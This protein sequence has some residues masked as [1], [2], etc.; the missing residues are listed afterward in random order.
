MK[1]II[2]IDTDYITCPL[3]DCR[4]VYSVYDSKRK[5]HKMVSGIARLRPSPTGRMIDL[6]EHHLIV[7]KNKRG[8]YELTCTKQEAYKWLYELREEIH[9]E[10][11]HQP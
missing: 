4:V 6:L 1:A 11:K 9:K 10:L 3:E 2:V 7:W 8:E 5:N